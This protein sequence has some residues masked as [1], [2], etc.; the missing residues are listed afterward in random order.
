[1]AFRPRLVPTLITIPVL[2]VLIALGVWQGQRLVWK[3]DLIDRIDRQLTLAPA[4]L[5]AAVADA[6][7][8][9]YRRVR[10]EGVLVADTELAV[11]SRTLDGRVGWHIISP[12][13]RADGTAVLINR[14]WVP[15]GVERAT[16]D[17]ARGMEGPI[18]VTAVARV[19]QP[20]GWLA[21]DNDPAR[22]TWYWIDLAAMAEAAG[23]VPADTAPVLLYADQITGADGTPPPDGQPVP[24]QV[25]I[26]IPNNHLHYMLTW[27]GLAV[28]LLGVYIAYHWRRPADR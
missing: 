15:D 7:A 13:I 17:R 4:A 11:A 6:A 2:I 21:L 27:Y 10:V 28:V 14:G 25:R 22:N 20:P 5:P 9:D 26:D 19:P 24:G 23:L 1:M 16:G 3:T 8:W 12:L 18:A